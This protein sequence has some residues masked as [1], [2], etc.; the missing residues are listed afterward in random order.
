MENDIVGENSTI[1]G[2]SYFQKPGLWPQVPARELLQRR[3]SSMASPRST[4]EAH[5]S[6]QPVEETADVEAGRE[7]RSAGLALHARRS[8]LAPP[9][10]G[11]VQGEPHLS[12]A[13]GLVSPCQFL[14]PAD[15]K[16]VPMCHITSGIRFSSSPC[17]M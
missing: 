7:N 11:W 10:G 1:W 3:R 14:L 4:Y 2:F 9:A 8:S 6:G 16:T 12:D 17:E 13:T 15:K 5:P